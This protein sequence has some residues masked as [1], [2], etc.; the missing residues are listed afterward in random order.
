MT[1]AHIRL[2]VLV[3]AGLAAGVLTALAVLPQAR[4]RLMPNR[5]VKVWGQALIGGPFSLVDHTG[6]RVTDADFRGRTMLIV[7]GSTASPDVTASS[8]QVL[9]AA[10]E[11]LGTKAGRAVP[12]LI[13]VDPERDTPERLERFV[14]RFGQRLVGLTGTRAEIDAVLRAY[15][16]Y[17]SAKRDMPESAAGVAVDSPTLIYVIGPDGRYRGHL[18]F[19]AGVDALARSLAG[20]L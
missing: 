7:F 14:E 17:L 4:E 5:H 11:K 9:M 13:A 15:R 16:V 3:L 8:L 10:L 2:V 19:T 20:M 1:A 12:I 18:S 6:K